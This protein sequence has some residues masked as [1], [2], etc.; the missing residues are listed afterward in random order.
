[1]SGIGERIR[2]CREECKISQ[3]QLARAIGITDKTISHIENGRTMPSIQTLLSIAKAVNSSPDF[4]LLG[5]THDRPPTE[6]S[7]TRVNLD[8]LLDRLTEKD[9]LEL[10][11]LA[12]I[13]V[14]SQGK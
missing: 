13:K 14:E 10:I 9:Y 8:R 7:F 12:K 2:Q 6:K 11:A 5:I 3:K 1:M 4:I